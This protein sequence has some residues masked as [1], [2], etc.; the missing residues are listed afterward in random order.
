[1]LTCF[2]CGR[3][4]HLIRLKTAMASLWLSPW[5]GWPFTAKISSPGKNDFIVWDS[6]ELSFSQFKLFAPECKY[7]LYPSYK[8]SSV[9]LTFIKFPIMAGLPSGKDC[10]DEDANVPLRRIPTTHDREPKRLLPMA[11]LK[12]HLRM[13][14]M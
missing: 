7:Q 14:S 1:M 13:R 3:H 10:L 8:T 4:I 6:L 5:R 12:H 2:R 9:E 11:L